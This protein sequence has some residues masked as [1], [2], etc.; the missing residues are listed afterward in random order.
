MEK[1]HL[2]GISMLENS[3][4][5]DNKL[6]GT[7]SSIMPLVGFYLPFVNYFLLPEM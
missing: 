4:S 1:C 6:L 3:M 5:E 2:V 7:T